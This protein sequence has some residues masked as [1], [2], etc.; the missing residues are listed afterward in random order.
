MAEL[1]AFCKR[2]SHR[3][4]TKF[5]ATPLSL[6]LYDV[7]PAILL[8]SLCI[9]LLLQYSYKIIVNNVIILCSINL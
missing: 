7:H 1:V 2:L 4:H 9:V 3:P 5:L 8:N 6:R